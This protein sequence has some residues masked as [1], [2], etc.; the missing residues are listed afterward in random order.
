LIYWKPV[1]RESS[2]PRECGLI[3]SAAFAEMGC[4]E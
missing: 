1:E 3:G 4:E 2:S